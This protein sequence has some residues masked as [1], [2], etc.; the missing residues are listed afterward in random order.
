MKALLKR[1]GITYYSTRID[2]RWLFS[3]LTIGAVEITQYGCKG[4]MHGATNV[5]VPRVGYVCFKPPTRA[6]GA[7][8]PWY[9]YISHDGTPTRA[10]IKFGIRAHRVYG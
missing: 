7:W 8:W 3:V 4:A 6:H 5:F 2:G 1:I 10:S 9:F